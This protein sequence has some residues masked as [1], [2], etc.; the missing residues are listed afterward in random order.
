M[1]FRKRNIGECEEVEEV[2]SECK[3]E[4]GL[5]CAFAGGPVGEEV[6]LEKR[7]EDDHETDEDEEGQLPV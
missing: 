7:D 2:G 5:E 1:L 4:G 3:S 6:A